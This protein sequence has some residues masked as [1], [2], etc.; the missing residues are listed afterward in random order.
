MWPYHLLS[1]KKPC[2]DVI[3]P[4]S[5]LKW[6]LFARH[7]LLFGNLCYKNKA[8]LRNLKAATDS[9]SE[10]AQFGSKSSVFCPIWPWNLTDDLEKQHGISASLF[11]AYMEHFIA[12][13]KFKLELQYGN[14]RFG[15]KSMIFLFHV[16][17]KLNEWP[18]KTKFLLCY[19]KI[20]AACR[21]HQ[22]IQTGVT[23]RKRLIW[24]KIGDFFCPVR[25]WNLTDDL[26]KQYDTPMLLQ[27]LC[28]TS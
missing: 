23:I 21:S 8:N 19:C 6:A 28:I 10:N 12:I 15:S 22:W 5:M 3:C 24:V 18:W 25:P 4:L 11:Q 2:L 20:C 7:I 27:A 16:I 9:Q 1:L 26:E 17:L 14:A 13:G